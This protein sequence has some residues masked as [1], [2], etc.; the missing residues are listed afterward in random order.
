MN[1]TGD[2]LSNGPEG[3]VGVA[4]GDSLAADVQPGFACGVNNR[5]EIGTPHLRPM[6]VSTEG[7]IAYNE[8][9]YVP[10]DR[11]DSDRKW[12]K[13]GDV[14]FNNT[15]SAELVG[16]TALYDDDEGVAFS[17]HMTRVRCTPAVLPKYCALAL[18]QKWREGYFLEHCNRH[19]SQASIGQKV[20][21][22]TMIPL[23]PLAEQE[24]IVAK[25]EALLSRVRSV[26]Q[27]LAAVPGI[28][29]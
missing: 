13:S 16:K 10:T 15:N 7:Q 2:N 18:H 1:R 27:R 26:R 25:A 6:N 23:P 5:D 28:L 3:W 11:V 22:A 19:V 29:N 9:K 21:K 17:N 14:L 4:L 20:L 24:R 8:V 12:L